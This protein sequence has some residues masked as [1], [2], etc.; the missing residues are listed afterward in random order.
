VITF[1]QIVLKNKR[2]KYNRRRKNKKKPLPG[3]GGNPQQRG[4]CLK[5][6]TKSPKKPNSAQ[7]KVAKIFLL[8]T[9]K[10]ITAYIPGE[11]HSLQDYAN[12]LI[13]GGGAKDVPGIHYKLMRGVRDL[14]GIKGR[15]NGR[16][17]YGTKR[18]L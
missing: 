3:L 1:T 5:T 13:Q 16:S 12:V 10:T 18:I 8:R 15:Q 14:K 4:M 7:R 9:H 6:F 17:K 11:G 2:N